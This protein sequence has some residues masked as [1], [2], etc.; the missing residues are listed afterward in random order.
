MKKFNTLLFLILMLAVGSTQAQPFGNEWIDFSKTYYKVKVGQDG[1]YRI[2]PSNLTGFTPSAND[3][4]NLQVF[5]KGQEIPIYVEDGNTNGMF[6]AS[7]YIQFYGKHNDGEADTPVY[8]DN[9]DNGG[10]TSENHQPHTHISLFS[11]TSAYFIVVGNA[12]GMR[13]TTISGE[14]ISG[15]PEGHYMHEVMELRQDRYNFGRL[16]L[17]RSF[18]SDYNETE[19]WTGLLTS[20]G[21]SRDYTLSTPNLVGGA[22]TPTVELVAIGSSKSTVTPNHHLRVTYGPNTASLNPFVDTTFTDYETVRF[23]K[24][25]I[26]A[27]IGTSTVFRFEIVNDL[28]IAPDGDDQSLCFIRLRY[29]RNFNLNNTSERN[30]YFTGAGGGSSR[31]SFTNYNKTMPIL[32]DLTNNLRITGIRSGSTFDIMVPNAGTEKRLYLLDET[33]AI[34]NPPIEVVNFRDL[35][36]SSINHE[37]IIIANDLYLTEA[38]AYAGYRADASPTTGGGGYDT[39]VVTAQQLANQFYFGIDHHPLAIRNFVDYMITNQA[40]NPQLLFLL[41]KGHQTD[42]LRT[43]VFL[44]ADRVPSYGTYG[45]DNMLMYGIDNNEYGPPIPVGRVSVNN[46]TEVMDYLDKVKKY[47]HLPK[48]PWQKNVLGTSGGNDNNEKIVFGSYKNTFVDNLTGLYGTNVFNLDLDRAAASPV[49][50]KDFVIEKVNE[51]LLMY[52]YFGHGSDLSIAVDIGDVETEYNNFCKYPFMF[53]SGCRVGNCF[54]E[55]ASVGES[56]VLAK[57]KGAIGWLAQSD[58]GYQTFLRDWGNLFTTNLGG[59]YYGQPVGISVQKTAENYPIFSDLSIIHAQQ[60]VLQMDP[61]VILYH[62]DNPDYAITKANLLDSANVSASSDQF[63]LELNVNNCGR[64]QNSQMNILVRQTLPNGQVI[65]HPVQRIDAP[66]FDATVLFEFTGKN[67][68]FAGMNSFEIIVDSDGEIT[69]LDETNNNFILNFNIPAS[70]VEYVWPKEYSIVSSN[71]VE[72]TIQNPFLTNTTTAFDIEV[73][74]TE[75]FNS[76]FKMTF[77][78]TPSHS[79]AS[80]NVNLSLNNQ[81]YFWRAKISTS[82]TY[83]DDYS[84]FTYINGSPKGWRQEHFG[85]YTGIQGKDVIVDV[86]NRYFDYIPH[87]IVI[88]AKN[89]STL[90]GPPGSNFGLRINDI[91][92]SGGGICGDRMLGLHVDGNTC[93]PVLYTNCNGLRPRQTFG[94]RNAAGRTDLVNFINAMNTGDVLA[95]FNIFGESDHLD[96]DPALVTAL[97]Q[98]GLTPAFLASLT[99]AHNF[100]F[101]G[102]K[103]FPGD[104]QVDTTRGTDRAVAYYVENC[105]WYEGFIT[106]EEIGPSTNWSQFSWNFTHPGNMVND[107]QYVGVIGIRS[108]GTEDT[109]FNNINVSPLDIST[110]NASI[111]PKIK[112]FAYVY[113]F[114]ERSPAQLNDWTVLYD[115]NYETGIVV[116][117]NYQFIADTLR[118]NIPA[119]STMQ[120]DYKVRN[121][122]DVNSDSLFVNYKII[123]P[124]STSLDNLDTILPINAGQT[125]MKTFSINVASPTFIDN[126]DNILDLRIYPKDLDKEEVLFNNSHCEYFH[127]FNPPLPVEFVDFKAKLRADQR[128]TDL[129]WQTASEINNEKF[130]ILR[131]HES[132]INFNEV[133]T[134]PGNGTTSDLQNYN[135]EDNVSALNNGLVY[136]Q[137]KQVDFDGK[138][139]FSEIRTIKIQRENNVRIYP[140]PVQNEIN[141]EIDLVDR[142]G[143]IQVEVLNSLGEKVKSNIQ[144]DYLDAGKNLRSFSVADLSEGNYTVRIK[145]GDKIVNKPIVIVK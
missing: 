71:M 119:Q 14:T 92:Q 97:G 87:N 37:Y 41:G 34:T 45:S 129:R 70:N 117:A 95:L 74:T 6:D 81:V 135:F 126:S 53:F 136:Y 13:I 139:S 143:N 76:P 125:V 108:N 80:Q 106:S 27:N 35:M 55:L 42:L 16:V 115:G 44:A 68:T 89:N 57:D 28:P 51:G 49:N 62:S 116:D 33:D 50:P 12:A 120:I 15:I 94:I 145:I 114:N 133:G 58:L 138:E 61:G 77:N 75:L 52:A 67:P 9:K 36:P 73:D 26:T 56:F 121:F 63:K 4:A 103:G 32:Y 79:L 127:V 17:Q 105:K 101:V 93:E 86:P 20:E 84:S 22:A 123:F 96:D 131:K 23:N 90:Q 39:L 112:L 99:H 40:I 54:G 130:I 38:K 10:V 3:I 60:S 25:I 118:K 2:T 31:L 144:F 65:I 83:P 104:V 107:Q 122:S 48:A 140:I 64:Y 85:Q 46:A 66:E 5:F 59:T 91:L 43:P 7:D 142:T 137:L 132:E 78:L 109:L 8:G 134:I 98:F 11:D 141:L 124:D 111:Y 128:F 102:K 29:P 30:L 82:P 19:G 18:R 21:N 69:E 47:E 24:N 110:I 1:M 100:T 88:T 113:D 72:L